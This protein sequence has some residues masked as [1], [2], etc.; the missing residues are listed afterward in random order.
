MRNKEV[1]EVF[2]LNV[3]KRIQYYSDELHFAI[4]TSNIFYTSLCLCEDTQVS[5]YFNDIA[6]LDEFSINDFNKIDI[7]PKIKVSIQLYHSYCTR[8]IIYL[9]SKISI[10]SELLKVNYVSFAQIITLYNAEIAKLILKGE[11]GTISRIGNFFISFNNRKKN[12]RLKLDHYKTKL[13]KKEL[14][15]QGSKEDYRIYNT[16]DQYI[17][18]NFIKNKTAANI[19][20]YWFDPSEHN[21][22]PHRKIELYY[23]EEHS[24]DDILNTTKIGNIQ[25]ANALIHNNPAYKLKYLQNAN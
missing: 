1:Y 9:R 6:F 2:K 7:D 19:D 3:V 22:L 23:T 12:S 25:K 18:F 11:K 14:E 4:S 21:N 24:D 17:F 20:Y 16:D 15:E 8:R 13:R 5:T 10:N